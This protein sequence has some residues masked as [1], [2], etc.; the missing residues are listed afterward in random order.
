VT[1]LAGDVAGGSFF[2]GF[3]RKNTELTVALQNNTATLIS[4][5]PALTT[6]N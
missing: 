2:V 6:K 1:R 5:H 3:T 4:Y